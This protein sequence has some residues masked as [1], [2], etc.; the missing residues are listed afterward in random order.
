MANRRPDPPPPTCCSEHGSRHLDAR[1][2][3]DVGLLAAAWTADYDED[4]RQR[5]SGS[6]Y[7]GLAVDGSEGWRDFAG[8]DAT[9]LCAIYTP[10]YLPASPRTGRRVS[11]AQAMAEWLEGRY[12]GGLWDHE[13]ELEELRRMRGLKV[14]RARARAT[15]R[16]FRGVARRAGYARPVVR[17]GRP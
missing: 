6:P 9:T 15:R 8:Y 16:T 12:G 1:K 11:Y 10:N 7:E 3:E 4:G 14:I 17:V 5:D 2:R 13:T